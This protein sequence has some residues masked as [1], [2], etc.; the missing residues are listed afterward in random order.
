MRVGSKGVEGDGS[1]QERYFQTVSNLGDKGVLRKESE[2]SPANLE[3]KRRDKYAERHHLR[4][5]EHESKRIA[6][7]GLIPMEYCTDNNVLDSHFKEVEMD[8]GGKKCSFELSL[9]A[10]RGST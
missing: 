9:R 1:V 6:V 2:E 8:A 7:G 4:R 10:S 3:G 5:K